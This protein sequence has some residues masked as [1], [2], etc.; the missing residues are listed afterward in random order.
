[1]QNTYLNDLSVTR[2][3]RALDAARDPATGRIVCRSVLDGSDP[4]RVPWNIFREGAVT[5]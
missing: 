5:Q 3:G 1:M 4:N 2:T